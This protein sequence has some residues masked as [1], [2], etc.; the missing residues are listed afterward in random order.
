MKLRCPRTGP[1]LYLRPV[2]VAYAERSLLCHLSYQSGMSAS[3]RTPHP[4]AARVRARAGRRGVL[5]WQGVAFSL[6]AR[7]K[8]ATN[9]RRT[10][11]S[12]CV[13]RL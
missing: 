2:Y 6:L 13:L 9:A 12:N 7:V 10:V 4:P 3:R 8:D 1:R 5:G 11:L